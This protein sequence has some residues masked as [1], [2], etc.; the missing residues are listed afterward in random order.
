MTSARRRRGAF[1]ALALTAGWLA[2]PA[3]ARP[4]EREFPL[5]LMTCWEARPEA[6]R[7]AGEPRPRWIMLVHYPTEWKP[8]AEGRFEMLLKV[9]FRDPDERRITDEDPF[10]TSRTGLCAPD[11][12]ALACRAVG[13]A[14]RWRIERSAGGLTLK[15]AEPVDLESRA[16]EAHERKRLAAGDGGWKLKD[17]PY[18]ACEL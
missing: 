2:P 18:G 1:I 11:G 13:A 12:E 4:L 3:L 8:D 9:S 16:A 10:E 17:V 5:A 7:L 15:I 6:A 14:G